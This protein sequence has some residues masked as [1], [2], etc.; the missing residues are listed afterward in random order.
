MAAVTAF[1]V[2]LSLWAGTLELAGIAAFGGFLTPFLVAGGTP[3]EFG[4]FGYL[5]ILNI[6]ILS[7]AFFK[8]WHGLTFLGFTG[9]VI[10]FASWYG[11]YYE[12]KKLSV[13]LV[14]LTMY[15]MTFLLAG[16]AANAVTRKVSARAG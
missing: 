1:G 9:T 10:N 7:V 6:G 11:A 2:I 3:N 4:F 8:K 16:F 12:P 13:A 14:A 5:T 15:Y